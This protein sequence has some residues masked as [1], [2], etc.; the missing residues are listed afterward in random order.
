MVYALP[1]EQD[2]TAKVPDEV[3]RNIEDYILNEDEKRGVG[4]RLRTREGGNTLLQRGNDRQHTVEIIVPRGV[5]TRKRCTGTCTSSSCTIRCWGHLFCVDTIIA[6]YHYG[7]ALSDMPQ[8]TMLTAS[9]IHSESEL[10]R[11]P[12]QSRNEPCE[13][14][15]RKKERKKERKCACDL[16]EPKW[17]FNPKEKENK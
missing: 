10:F 17:L 2:A 3:I 4:Y 5:H 15:R 12:L 1:I 6:K 7:Q 8:L 16:V 13:R 11:D 9:T 14:R